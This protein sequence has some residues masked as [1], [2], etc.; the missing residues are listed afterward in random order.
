[1]KV[2]DISSYQGLPDWRQVRLAGVQGVIVKSTEGVTYRNPFYARQIAGARAE[3]LLVGHYHFAGGLGADAEF[4][5]FRVNVNV[6]PADWVVLDAE[7]NASVLNTAW[8]RNWLNLAASVYHRRPI[9]YSYAP[10]IRDHL[11]P[12]TTIEADLWLAAYTASP[13]QAP[14][15]WTEWRA[16]QFTSSGSIPGI[17]G[18]VDVSDWRIMPHDGS[19]P[20]PTP[21][22]LPVPAPV[23]SPVPA[24]TPRKARTDMILVSDTDGKTFLVSDS[25]VEA[26][27][28]TFYLHLAANG[29]PH[30]EGLHPLEVVALAVTRGV[31]F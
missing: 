4:N 31:K 10:W 2:I 14:R 25:H 20:A 7:K 11:H 24:P 12:A 16:W 1:M 29:L 13:P 21:A 3:G 18:R 27:T 17:K 26:I 5:H 8:V 15:P 19:V 30:A 22:P 6:R 28:P 9:F 23:P